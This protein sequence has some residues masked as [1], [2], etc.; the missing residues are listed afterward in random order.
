MSTTEVTH[1]DVRYRTI[2]RYS[3][4]GKLIAP[5]GEWVIIEG[6]EGTSAKI[7]GLKSG[8]SYEVQVRAVNQAGPGPWSPAPSATTS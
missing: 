5:P 1:Y 2:A 8:T 6:I 4:E 3:A 7:E